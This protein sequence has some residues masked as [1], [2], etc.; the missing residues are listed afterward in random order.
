MNKVLLFIADLKILSH[1]LYFTTAAG[2]GTG[3]VPKT[4]IFDWPV[5]TRIWRK[6]TKLRMQ[7]LPYIY[8]QAH[9]AHKVTGSFLAS[10][11]ISFH[12]Q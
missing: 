1:V 3:F 10:Y 8:T 9:I 12:T 7:L 11:I 2:G 5:G 6:Y 4:H